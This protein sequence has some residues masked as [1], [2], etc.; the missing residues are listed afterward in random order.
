MESAEQQAAL[1]DLDIH[2]IMD[3]IPHRYPFLMIDKLVEIVPHESAVAIK[4]VSI[5]EPYFQGHFP[6]PT[7]PIMPGV[8]IVEAM[9]QAAACLVVYSLGIARE[10]RSVY[11]MSI[12]EARFRKPVVPGD[13]LRIHVKKQRHRANVWRFAAEAKVN[14]VLVAEAVY[15]AMIADLN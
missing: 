3:C 14:G 6:L 8:L 9:A 4:N 13:Q 5:N 10:H 7:G 2:K 11:F 1:P 12:E 15:T